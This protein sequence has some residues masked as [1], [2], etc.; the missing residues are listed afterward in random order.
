VIGYGAPHKPGTYAAHGDP[1]GTDEVAATKR[2]YDWPEDE[3]F[4]V[5]DR[6]REHFT[7][8]MADN[9]GRRRREWE[10]LFARYA[11]KYS[12]QANELNRMQRRTLPDGWDADLPESNKSRLTFDGAGDFSA[13]DRAGRNLHFGV[14][15]H[16]AAAVCTLSLFSAARFHR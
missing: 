15:E 16:A 10:D 4:L 13:E 7:A 3:T 5:P 2:F 11:Q 12:E 1:L 14:R 6:V 8:A 9:G